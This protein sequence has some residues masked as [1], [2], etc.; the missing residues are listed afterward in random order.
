[1]KTTT[2]HR[3]TTTVLLAVIAI[4]T[5]VTATSV[6]VI[7]ALTP[8]QVTVTQPASGEPPQEPQREDTEVCHQTKP[9]PLPEPNCAP[10]T[11]EE[12]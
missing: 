6:T 11:T 3:I 2:T 9:L 10:T 8:V 4:A 12:V 5:T 7:A 1:M